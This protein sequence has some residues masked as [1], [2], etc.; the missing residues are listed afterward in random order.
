MN[1]KSLAS[2][3][4]EFGVHDTLR[5]G[6]RSIA[7]EL[8]SNHPLEQRLAQWG[9]TEMNMK[10]QLHRKVYGLHA[11][12]RTLMERDILSKLHHN[13]LSK[14]S[15]IALDVFDGKDETIDFEDFLNDP[16]FSSNMYDIHSTLEKHL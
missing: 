11:P 4:N 13:P 15:N 7:N 9:E 14:Y 6:M 2:T 3:C 1:E 5:F 10:N 12:L 8:V 16:D